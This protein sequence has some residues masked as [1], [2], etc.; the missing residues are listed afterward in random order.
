MQE[1][2][3]G[4]SDLAQRLPQ[5]LLRMQPM[6]SQILPLHREIRMQDLQGEDL[7]RLQREL[8]DRQ[9]GLQD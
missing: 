3:S 4:Y 6:Q 9:A 1:E 2:S 8:S 7:H 5:A